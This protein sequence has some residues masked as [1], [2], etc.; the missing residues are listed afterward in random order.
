MR[1]PWKTE[2]DLE[3]GMF[4]RKQGGKTHWEAEWDP[5]YQESISSLSYSLHWH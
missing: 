3:K 1:L 5:T 4:T 2:E